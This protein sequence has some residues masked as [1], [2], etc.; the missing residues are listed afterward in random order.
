MHLYAEKEVMSLDDLRAV[1]H[2]KAGDKR[3]CVA[4]KAYAAECQAPVGEGSA[5]MCW[6]CAHHV[7][8]H[9][10]PLHEAMEAR[11]ECTP[12]QVYPKHVIAARTAAT[13][14]PSSPVMVEAFRL[15]HGDVD[16][17]KVRDSKDLLTGH[18]W[19]AKTKTMDTVV[20]GEIVASFDAN[21]RL[22]RSKT[23]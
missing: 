3:L 16:Y 18:V 9:D 14:A 20:R 23:R 8:D 22:V 17:T 21:D 11:C 10:V 5:P 4:C 2:P 7:V 15:V 12:D 19:N 1:K 13:P 6:L